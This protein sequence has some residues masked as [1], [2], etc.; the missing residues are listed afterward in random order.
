MVYQF[1]RKQMILSDLK[2]V[3]KFLSSP[4]N[5]QVIT[6]GFLGFQVVSHNMPGKIYPGQIII[7]QVKPVLK[8]R[9]TWVTE[10][11]H[12]RELFY[13]VDEQRAG[14][15][16]MWHHEHILETVDRGVEVVDRITYKL[17]FGFAGRV[18]HKSLVLGQLNK[19]FD[20]RER[21]LQELFNSNMR[22]KNLIID[23]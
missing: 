3:W 10:I 15:F 9:M 11:T 12:V 20:Y 19:I 18:F 13:F 21:K 8:L 5:L 1:L 6:P 23:V 17:P 22:N 4:Q 2:S 7:Y 16:R 14:P